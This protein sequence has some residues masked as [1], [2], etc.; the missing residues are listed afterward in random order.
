MKSLN[1]AIADDRQDIRDGLESSITAYLEATHQLQETK[2]TFY[3]FPNPMKL[4]KFLKDDNSRIDLLFLDIS[5]P[6][7]MS[8]LEALP[9]IRYLAPLL[10]III[11]TGNNDPAETFQPYQ[12]YKFGYIAKADN[13]QQT[14]NSVQ[15]IL[16]TIIAEADTFPRKLLEIHSILNKYKPYDTLLREITTGQILYEQYRGSDIDKSAMGLPWCRAFEGIVN[17]IAEKN[18]CKTNKLSDT[19]YNL[20]NLKQMSNNER[21]NLFTLKNLRNKICHADQN[22]KPT[23]PFRP[24]QIT[25][26]D[27]FKELFFGSQGYTSGILVKLLSFL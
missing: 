14:A 24:T 5:F 3:K 13:L 17:L 15:V 9:S 11:I 12:K 22:D 27:K 25:D 8:G 23:D 4:L 1:I 26:V 20:C 18:D 21:D 16:D 6:G 19:I 7:Y 2:P 10:T